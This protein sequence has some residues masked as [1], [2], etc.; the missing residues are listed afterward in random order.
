MYKLKRNR[1]FWTI[2]LIA[3]ALSVLLHYLIIIDWWSMSGTV[4]NNAGIGKLNAMAPFTTLL[5]FNLIVSP[6]AGFFLSVEFS[7]SRSIKNQMMSGNKRSHIFL[8][9]FL[10]FSLGAVIVAVII[11]LVIGIA[12]V[13]LLGHGEIFSSQQILFLGRAFSLFLFHFFSY[14]AIMTLLAIVTEDSGKTIIFS[15]IMTIVIFIIE[16]FSA[17]T[18]VAA[19]YENTFFH[20]LTSAFQFTMTYEEMAKS[21]VIGTVS[22]VVILMFSMFIMNRKEIK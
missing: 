22:L 21:I 19:I 10:V 12:M 5:F 9:K 15:I 6:L 11:P 2:S 14:T 17:G 18:F 1:S 3:A 16:K 20:E 8:A 13:L 4:F 7:Q